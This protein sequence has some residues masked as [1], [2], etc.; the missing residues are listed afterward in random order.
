LLSQGHEVVL[1]GFD[2]M[3]EHRKHHWSDNADRGLW[4]DGWREW[5]FFADALMNKKITY[6]GWDPLKE[7]FPVVRTPV[8]CGL[9]QNINVLREP[10]QMGWY[11]FFAKTLYQGGCVLDVGAGTCTGMRLYETLGIPQ[12][13]GVEWDERLRGI[14]PGLSIVKDLGEIPDKSYDHVTSMDVLEHVVDD[15]PFFNHM[16]RIAKRSVFL[17]TP[18]GHRSACL[19]EAHCREYTVPLFAN[20]FKPNR[21][22]SGAPD[23]KSHR[24]L[25]LEQAGSWHINRG[26]EGMGN[27]RNPATYTAHP[28]GG[29][30]LSTR[31]NITVDGEEWPHIAAEF[32]AS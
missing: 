27:K 24:T 20:V 8:P 13:A 9:D 7:G 30:P 10:C 25:L 29:M 18:N 11:E 6:L 15:I 2:F 21:L 32:S 19:N 28:V 5:L 4:H 31:F 26:E 17:T 3:N 22:W 23:G 1:W 16:K 14:H 12:V